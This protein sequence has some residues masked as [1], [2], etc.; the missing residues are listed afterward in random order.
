MAWFKRSP[1][2]STD[3]FFLLIIVPYKYYYS[4]TYLLACLLTRFLLI[5][6]IL[7]MAVLWKNTRELIFTAQRVCIART[8]PWQDVCLSVCLYVCPSVRHTPVLCVN[9]YT[10][11]QSFFTIG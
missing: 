9:C 10:Y 4:L 6:I 8:M 7:T 3:E 1:I 2:S 11:P 5:G